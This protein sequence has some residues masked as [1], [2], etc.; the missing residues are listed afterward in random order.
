[1]ATKKSY[2]SNVMQA[3]ENLEDP[4]LRRK[5]GRSNPNAVLTEAQRLFVVNYVDHGMTQTAAARAAGSTAKNPGAI[6][7][8]WMS[9]PK[10]QAAISRRRAEYAVASQVTKKQ[11]IDGFLEAIA[12]GKLKSD[13]LAMIAGWR[14]VGKM[15]GFYEPTRAK[16]EVSVQGQMV[17][18]RMNE[19]SDEEL[20]NVIEGDVRV[21]EEGIGGENT[22]TPPLIALHEDDPPE[23]LSG[24]GA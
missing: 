5:D 20:L 7:C 17:I 18:Q 24:L 13:S 8:E 10:V 2:R 6:A 3:P 4:R 21:I 11:V 16:I 19:M 23:V 1:M 14:E 9:L 12:M 15:C 22:G